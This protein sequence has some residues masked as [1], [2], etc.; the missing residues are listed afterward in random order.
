MTFAI[1]QGPTVVI[2]SEYD[3]SGLWALQAS[4]LCKGAVRT[5]TPTVV[6]VDTDQHA[7]R[8]DE[9]DATTYY[10]EYDAQYYGPRGHALTFAHSFCRRACPCFESLRSA[11]EVLADTVSAIANPVG[12]TPSSWVTESQQ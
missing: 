4:G 2:E 10:G 5:G 1:P 9:K 6:H 11:N 7:A 12:R 8:T 3:C